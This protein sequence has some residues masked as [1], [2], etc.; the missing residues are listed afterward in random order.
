[1]GYWG[2]APWDNDQAA[3]YFAEVFEKSKI[4]EVIAATLNEPVTYENCDQIR[5]AIMLFIQLGH[6]YIY[7]CDSYEDHLELC[8]KKNEELTIYWKDEG[9][10]D[11]DPEFGNWL[12]KERSI[13]ERRLSNLG[14]HASKRPALSPDLI[15]WWANWID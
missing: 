6:N 11:G 8:L 15:K 14:V 7:D 9:G 5:G 4:H 2:E 13:L 1:M 10:W 3:D 12:K